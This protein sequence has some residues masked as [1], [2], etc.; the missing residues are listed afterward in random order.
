VVLCDQRMPELSG[1]ELFSQ[2]K[3]LHPHTV[4]ILLTGYTQIDAVVDTVNR[5]WVYKF[6]TKPWDDEL[7]LGHVRDAYCYYEYVQ[8]RAVAGAPPVPQRG[9]A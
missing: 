1:T 2:V 5:G 6:I 8:V 7:L 3:A 9:C 4:R